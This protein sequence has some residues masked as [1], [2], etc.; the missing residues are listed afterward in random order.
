MSNRIDTYSVATAP[1]L[2]PAPFPRAWVRQGN[3]TASA[4]RLWK[5]DDGT[6]TTLVW[7]CTAG[8]FEWHYR[9]E[10]TVHILEGEVHVSIAG[11]NSFRLG[12]GDTALFR[13]GA[14][15]VWTVKDRVRKVAIC[16]LAMP[17]VVAFPYRAWRKIVALIRS[18]VSGGTS[19]G[20]AGA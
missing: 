19:A 9:E 3:P 13:A 10:E 14:H 4:T 5:S 2:A 7:E 12:P 11:G 17:R 16:R 8:T 15:A 18:R 6:A 1:S 20:L